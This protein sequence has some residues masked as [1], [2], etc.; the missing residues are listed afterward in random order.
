MLDLLLKHVSCGMLLLFPFS[1]EEYQ[2][3]LIQ[4]D[5]YM[6]TLVL[7]VLAV[8]VYAVTEFLSF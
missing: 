5:D 8:I 3:G 4:C 1:W 6:I 2:L 7:V